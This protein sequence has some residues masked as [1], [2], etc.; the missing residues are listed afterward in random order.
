MI[1][2]MADTW[3]RR[4][5]EPEDA[6]KA[7]LEF[8]RRRMHM[9]STAQ[10]LLTPTPEDDLASQ[11]DW[12]ARAGALDAEVDRRMALNAGRA[13]ARAAEN[14]V[15][16]AAAQIGE[17]LDDDT[18]DVSAAELAGLQETMTAAGSLLDFSLGFVR[19][20]SSHPAQGPRVATPAA[21]DNG[22]FDDSQPR[23]PEPAAAQRHAGRD[24]DDQRRYDPRRTSRDDD[25]RTARAEGAPAGEHSAASDG[26]SISDDIPDG[27]PISDDIPDGDPISDDIPDGDPISDDIPDGD[28]ISDDIPDGDPISDDI[29]DGDPISDDIP[30]GDPISEDAAAHRNGPRFKAWQPQDAAWRP[31]EAAARYHGT[32]SP[33]APEPDNAA[34]R[35][36][37]DT[38]P[39]NTADDDAAD[40]PDDAADDDDTAPARRGRPRKKLVPPTPGPKCG[41]RGGKADHERRDE[42]LCDAC[43]DYLDEF[44]RAASLEPGAPEPEPATDTSGGLTEVIVTPN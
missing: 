23:R 14:L 10:E 37:T 38:A 43:L 12:R 28:P 27:D 9:C 39:G 17:S 42:E 3:L 22:A 31:P 18:E 21:P 44:N 19:E 35:D 30:D 33:P 5:D 25:G 26:Q 8:Y 4:P 6:Y 36:D 40:G 11:H 15:I 24:A 13:I 20:H 41:Q 29:P 7:F 34:D 32:V 16:S 1:A 2:P